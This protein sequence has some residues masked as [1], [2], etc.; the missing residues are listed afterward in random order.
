M[1]RISATDRAKA[2]AY[3]GASRAVV[4]LIGKQPAGVLIASST[5]AGINAGAVLSETLAAFGGRGGGS[6]TLAQGSIADERAVEA[7]AQKLGL[8]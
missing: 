3:V 2:L 8:L 6:A 7:L 4:L 1:E 5:D